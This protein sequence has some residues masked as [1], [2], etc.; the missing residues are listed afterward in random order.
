MPANALSAPIRATATAAEVPV[1]APGGA[2]EKMFTSSEI[3][4]A[5]P[6]LSIA[7]SMR[8]CILSPEFR[9]VRRY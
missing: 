5:R 9:T 3:S 4:A 6:M 2:E 8:G 7:A 1:E